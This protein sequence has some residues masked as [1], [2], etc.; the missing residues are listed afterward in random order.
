[1]VAA[2]CPRCASVVALHEGRPFV[3]TN[4][5]VE[6]WHAVCWNNRHVVVVAE[7]SPMPLPPVVLSTPVKPPRRRTAFVAAGFASLAVGVI[8]L[9]AAHGDDAIGDA[10]VEAQPS[11]GVAIDEATSLRTRSAA[12]ELVPPKPRGMQRLEDEFPIPALADKPIDATFASLHGWIHPITSADELFPGNPGRH[13]GAGRTGVD[14]TECGG[15]H[16]GV[17]LDGPKG[18]ALVA[19]AAGTLITVERRELGS[20]GRSGRF[21]RI[22]HEDGTLTSYMHMDAIDD[23]LQPGDRVRA[24]QYLGTLGDSAVPGVPHLHFALEVPLHPGSRDTTFGS[25]RF[26]DPAPF[27]I[28]A[29]IVER[30]ERRH[31]IKPVL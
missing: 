17:D 23:A 7:P 26:V 10:I 27:L 12:H 6:L 11:A 2:S 4:G 30:A 8:A 29:T 1:M 28:R 14:R 18:R 21:V 31:A 20:D 15:G 19:V 24:G 3:T 5:T 13:F 9:R 16:C 22:Q 25:V